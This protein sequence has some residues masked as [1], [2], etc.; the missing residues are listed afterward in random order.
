MHVVKLSLSLPLTKEEFDDEKQAKFKESIA[1]AAGASPADVSIDGVEGISSA[2]RRL[3]ASGIRIDV[4]V[5]AE[6]NTAADAM[7]AGLTV[8][9]I[10]A[11]LSKA[12]LPR[13]RR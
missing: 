5:K 6:D 10:N 8:D 11:E 13:A 12:G 4:S 3:L 2:R 7:V 1:K 9:N